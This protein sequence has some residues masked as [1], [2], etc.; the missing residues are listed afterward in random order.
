[1]HS[2]S[3][4]A[5]SVRDLAAKTS[6]NKA[7]NLKLANIRGL[8]ALSFLTDFVNK[9]EADY[10]KLTDPTTNQELNSVLKVTSPKVDG[11][12]I[13]GWVEYGHY[14]V[15]GK[16]INVDN[17][18]S[19]YRKTK[20][21]SDINHLYFCF[22]VPENKYKGIALFHKIGNV[23]VKGVLEEKINED[24][25]F[26]AWSKGLKLRIKPITKATDTKQWM[27]KAQV[28]KIVLEKFKDKDKFSD[29]AN[30]LDSGASFEM[31][32][33]APRGE[34]LGSLLDWNSDKYSDTVELLE[35]MCAEVKSVIEVG[36]KRRVTSLSNTGT[37]SKVEITSQDVEMQ[38][39]FPKFS[40]I[41]NYAK[42]LAK[43]LINTMG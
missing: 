24:S 12:F 17:S 13:S 3:M 20:K 41:D 15:P 32:I 6:E 8:D 9:L 38:E 31:T 11:R 7:G 4:Y 10:L 23:G 37:E 30:R 28:K 26:P 5:L 2:M 40:S 36:G 42:E 35:D 29:V 39:N 14:G 18:Q 22:Y 19:V 34:F 16:I 21:D 25:A 27:R 1:M 43:E 33:V